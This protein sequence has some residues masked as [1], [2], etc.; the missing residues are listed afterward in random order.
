[1]KK[2]KKFK[3]RSRDDNKNY[4]FDDR[5]KFCPFSQKNSPLIDYKDIKLL[6]RY[7]SEKGKIT[8]SRITNV[9]R[10]KQLELS[11]AIKRARFLGLMSYTNKFF[12]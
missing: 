10:S 11:K 5:K 7:I 4:P 1:M 3:S 12:Y 8:P 9:S 2:N 6:S